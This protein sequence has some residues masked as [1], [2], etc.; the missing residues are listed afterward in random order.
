LVCHHV[1]LSEAKET[2]A[3]HGLLRFAQDDNY[4][5]PQDDNYRFPQDD[6]YRF[7]QDDNYRFPFSRSMSLRSFLLGLPLSGPNTA[8]NDLSWIASASRAVR[9]AAVSS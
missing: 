3:G 6:N 9:L 7:P 4:R 5:F 8:C 2:M 1:I